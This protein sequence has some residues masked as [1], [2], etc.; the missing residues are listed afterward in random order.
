MKKIMQLS[1]DL[2]DAALISDVDIYNAAIAKHEKN[3][4]TDKYSPAWLS[5]GQTF[6]GRFRSS[7]EDDSKQE[8]LGMEEWL[9]SVPNVQ[10]RKY[11]YIIDVC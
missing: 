3:L 1:D 8:A 5:F 4:A 10:A 11:F 9:V 7:M 2:G 6:D